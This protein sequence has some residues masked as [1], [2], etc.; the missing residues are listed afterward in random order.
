MS[1]CRHANKEKKNVWKL[2]SRTLSLRIKMTVV[3]RMGITATASVRLLGSFLF[4]RKV[5]VPN[6]SRIPSSWQCPGIIKR[7]RTMSVNGTSP[8]PAVVLSRL[9]CQP[10]AQACHKILQIGTRTLPLVMRLLSRTFTLRRII[11]LVRSTELPGIFLWRCQLPP[12]QSKRHHFGQVTLINV[13]ISLFIVIL[14][15]IFDLFNQ[16]QSRIILRWRGP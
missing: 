8:P 6:R 10:G 11:P 4:P 14:I 1:L 2:S 16:I 5:Q 7:V 15:K 3:V 9:T 12:R 13:F